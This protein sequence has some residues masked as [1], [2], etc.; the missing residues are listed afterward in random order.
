MEVKYTL[1][2]EPGKTCADCQFYKPNP[3][4]PGIGDCFGHEV[5][6]QGSCKMFQPKEG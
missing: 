6:A 1:K 2:G 3:D 5:E 4:N